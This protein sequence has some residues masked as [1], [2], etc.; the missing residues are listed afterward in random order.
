MGDKLS[1]GLKSKRLLRRWQN[2]KRRLV[3]SLPPLLERCQANDNAEVVHE[4]RVAVRRLRLYVRLGRPLL[5]K[6]SVRQFLTWARSVLKATSPLR[7]VNVAMEWLQGRDNADEASERLLAQRAK[8]WQAISRSL[9]APGRGLLKALTRLRRSDKPHARLARRYRKIAARISKSVYRS[10]PGFFEMSLEEQ[11]QLRRL[12]RWW[13]YLLE[14]GLPRR[15]QKKDR[16]L[17]LLLELQEAMG[18]RQ[19]LMLCEAALKRYPRLA[20]AKELQRVLAAEQAAASGRIRADM[21]A[22]QRF[23]RAKA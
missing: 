23:H 15:A 9:Q 17:L 1:C 21:R 2:R 22:L 16:L 12:V 19:D 3:E 6:K 7:D 14:V 13:R 10:A 5:P 11:H 4:L 18:D 8:L 20:F